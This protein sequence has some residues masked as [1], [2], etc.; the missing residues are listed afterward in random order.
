MNNYIVLY[1]VGETPNQSSFR[2][3]KFYCDKYGLKLIYLTDIINPNFDRTNQ[4]FYIF[5]IFK[6]NNIDYDNICFVSDVTLIN[7]NTD[8]LFKLTNNK[9]T[10]AEW[11]GDFGYLWNNIELYQNYFKK[12]SLDYTRF[13]DLGFFVIQKQHEIIFD[14]ILSFLNDNYQEL[15]SKLD[16]TFI[17][18]NFFFDCE[19]NKLPYTYNMIDMNRKEIVVD[20]NL[21][22]L[23]NIFNFRLSLEYMSIAVNML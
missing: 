12:E 15:K 11:D 13:F 7:K 18:Q 21:S 22:K 4:I 14:K 20:K 17:P 23:G 6:Q 9:L 10:F 2:N 19:Y 5:Q 16:T 8:N 3:W 1:Q